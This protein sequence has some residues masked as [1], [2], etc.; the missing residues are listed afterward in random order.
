MKNDLVRVWVDFFALVL[1]V[2]MNGL[3][4]AL[5]FNNLTTGE[6]SDRFDV[7]FVPAGY[8]FAIWGLIYLALGAFAVYQLLPTQRSNPRLRAVG[9]WFAASCLANI[10]WLFFWHYLLF[11]LTLLA[12]LAL[13][14]CLIMIY[15][16]LNI[17]RSSVST[18]ERW[19]VEFPFSLYLGWVSVATIA[20]VTSLLD[21]LGWGGWGI[22]PQ[23]WAMIMLTVGVVLAG[24]VAVQRADVVYLL[25]FIWAYIGIAVAQ[26]DAPLV[27]F[28][29]WIGAVLLALVVL[30]ITL[31]MWPRPIHA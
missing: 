16:K 5:P 4:N 25:V 29:A 28:S 1:T 9:Y 13:L 20:N 31:R 2:L 24:I 10:A 8:V 21:V 27:V 18:T 26:A 30:M 3:A 11:P 22:S 12:M 23:I 15:L 6:I 17:G 19:L 7:Y 14:A